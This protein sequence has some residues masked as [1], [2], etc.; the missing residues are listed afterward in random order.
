MHPREPRWSFHLPAEA[1]R[2]HVRFAGEKPIALRA[3]A[4]RTVY[5]QPD[6]DRLTLVW[7]AELLVPAAPGPKRLEG[8]EHAVLWSD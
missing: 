5:V 7:T 4:I 8:L 2:M 3:P 1:P 6:L